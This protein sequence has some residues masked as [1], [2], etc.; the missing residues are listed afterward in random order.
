MTLSALLSYFG[1]ALLFAAAV[2]FA[3]G[4]SR[5]RTRRRASVG[6][7]NAPEDDRALLAAQR[8]DLLCGTL[9]LA[10]AL[11]AEVVSFAGGGPAFGEPDGNTAG[12]ALLIALA[13]FLCVM[14]CLVVRHLV[15]VRVRRRLDD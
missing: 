6:K 1:V 13:T 15:V 11:I 14:V 2:F 5:F 8:A 4:I 12:G 10:V 3:V 9:L 7:Y